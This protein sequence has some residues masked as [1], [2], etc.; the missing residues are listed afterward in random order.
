MNKANT[1]TDGDDEFLIAHQIVKL[2]DTALSKEIDDAKWTEAASK[3]EAV[4]KQLSD[5]FRDKVEKLDFE[6]T[7]TDIGDFEKLK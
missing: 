5:E 1:L 6:M 2:Y 3:I 4:D 7:L